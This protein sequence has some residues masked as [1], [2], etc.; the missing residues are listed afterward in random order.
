M[1]CK[2]IIINIVVEVRI[3]F[4]RLMPSDKWITEIEI[5]KRTSP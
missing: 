2:A 4:K 1:V 5:V 3:I